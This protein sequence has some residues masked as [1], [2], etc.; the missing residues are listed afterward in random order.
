M[1]YLGKVMFK[2]LYKNKKVLITGHTG[3]KGSWLSIW[4]LKLG[5]KVYGISK[6]IPTDPSMFKN[7][8]LKDQINNY[9]TDIKNLN[10][11]KT[12]INDVKAGLCF[13]SCCSA[14]SII[15]L[16]KSN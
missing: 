2:N 3:F 4:L 9:K 15:I 10:K 7:L 11:I 16:L 1:G 13:S 8:Q 6:D 12:I 14:I 5:A